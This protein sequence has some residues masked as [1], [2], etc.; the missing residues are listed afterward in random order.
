MKI[1]TVIARILVGFV[2]VFF[3]PNAFLHRLKR[4]SLRDGEWRM[5]V[6]RGEGVMSELALGQAG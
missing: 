6:R 1:A 5:G 4:R 2:F 3:G